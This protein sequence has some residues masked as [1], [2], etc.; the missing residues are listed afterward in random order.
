MDW[1]EDKARLFISHIS[2][3]K[4]TASKVSTHLREYDIHA[5]V[6][7]E[8]IQPSKIWREEIIE[9]LRTCDAVALLLHDGFNES[10]W[11]DQEVG[12]AYG[13]GKRIIPVRTG[14][15]MPY[16]FAG[17]VQALDCRGQR[18]TAIAEAIAV[19]MQGEE[20]LKVRF[21]MADVLPLRSAINYDDANEKMNDIMGA[22]P[23]E[24]WSTL[25]GA[26][27]R[28]AEVNSQVAG[29]FTVQRFLEQAATPSD[30]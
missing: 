1:Q 11:C 25:H 6:A 30:D 2:E 26:V 16:G 18:P 10:D 23:R 8:D 12:V 27:S 9:A 3:R 15:L 28:I 4:R 17:E 24:D 19:L 22:V 13:E 21:Y 20:S 5:F 14:D 29:A 7:H